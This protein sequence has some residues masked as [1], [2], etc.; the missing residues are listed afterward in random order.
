MAARRGA[1]GKP[2]GQKLHLHID[3]DRTLGEVFEVTPE[4]LKSALKRHSAVAK[5]LRVT[6]DWDSAEFDRHIATAEVLWGWRFDRSDLARRAPRLR[7]VHAPGAGIN[8]LMPLDW[9]PNGAVF[10]NSSGVHGQRATEYAFMAVL[11]LNNRLPEMLANQRQARWEQLFSTS[12]RGK[13]LLI[14]GVGHVGGGVA[15]WAKRA[16]MRVVGVR[17]TGKPHRHVDEMHSP[18]A[19]RRLMPRADFV[20]VTAPS[21]PQTRHLLGAAE[22]ALMK[23]GA[24]LVNYSRADL[25]DYD[26]LREKLE[27]REIV[28][29]L[30]VFN[31]EPLPSSSP[32]WRTPN[33]IMTPH[34][35]SDDPGYYTPRTLDLLLENMARYLAG[36][37]LRNRVSPKWQ[38]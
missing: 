5:R 8:H 24:G 12:I 14:I 31:P 21:T 36:K 6:L 19:I 20:L 2:A 16:G 38:Y 18:K 7:W 29:V 15:E 25:V 17:R 23:P 4:R 1:G 27:R 35:S 9:L 32:L 34:S 26:A 33:L 28:A 22:L 37:P 10:T 3:N 11:M 13:T 30:D